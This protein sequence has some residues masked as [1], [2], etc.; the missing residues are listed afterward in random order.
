[1]NYINKKTGARISSS[2][3]NRLSYSDRSNYMESSSSSS[4]SGDFGLSMIVGAATDS[5]LLGGLIGG[6]MIG[7]MLGDMMDGDLMD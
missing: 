7:G 2:D 6:D 1:M 3:Y 5:A 4:S